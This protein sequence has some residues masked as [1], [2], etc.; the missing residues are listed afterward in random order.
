M[1]HY[2]FIL[3]VNFFLTVCASLSQNYILNFVISNNIEGGTFYKQSIFS[4]RKI[5][6]NKKNNLKVRSNEYR[7]GSKLVTID[8]FV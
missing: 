5:K 4:T 1:E 2:I 6:N 8:P 7:L 3:I